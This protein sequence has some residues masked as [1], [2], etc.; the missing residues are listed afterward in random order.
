MHRLK[1]VPVVA[2]LCAL[3]AGCSPASDTGAAQFV[4]STQRAAV[5]SSVVVRIQVTISG[6]D[7]TAFS[8]DLVQ[9]NGTW[10]GT[11][12]GIPAGI[13]RSFLLTAFDSS[14]KRVY[15][16]QATGVNIVEGQTALIAVTLQEVDVP[17]HPSNDVPVIDSVVASSTT[18]SGGQTI[19]LAATVHDPDT[20]DTLTYSWTATAGSLSSPTSTTTNWTAPNTSLTATLT[21]T[22]QDSRGGVSSARLFIQVGAEQPEGGLITIEVSFNSPPTLFSFTASEGRVRVGQSTT[23]WAQAGDFDG[24]GLS[25]L[26]TS[27]CPGTFSDFY[28]LVTRFTPSSLPDSSTCNNCRI[29]VSIYDG[30]GAATTGIIN[31]CVVPAES[32]AP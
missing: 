32:H 23:L 7:F 27:S 25:P 14:G 18:V 12:A 22:V 5:D 15:E 2:I 21:L 17:P 8:Q 9:A 31:I 28:S 4:V 1:F 26:W 24:G 29:T 20:T 19:N 10:G 13:N 3:A 30:Q 11:I 6:P 16:G